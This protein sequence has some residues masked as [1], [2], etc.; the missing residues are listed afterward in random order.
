VPNA[1]KP[2][3]GDG[4]ERSTVGQPSREPID[5]SARDIPPTVELAATLRTPNGGEAPRCQAVKRDGT[6]CG[7]PAR[8]GMRVCARHGGG[9][10]ARDST[11]AGPST[12]SGSRAAPAGAG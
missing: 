9:L 2:K 1:K 8:K 12:R 5:R 7:A 10:A 11:S 6:Q 3:K 4:R